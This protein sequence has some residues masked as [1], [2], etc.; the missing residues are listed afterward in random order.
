MT[1]L[2]NKSPSVGVVWHSG[3]S[4]WYYNNKKHIR[5]VQKQL[6]EKN[7]YAF[8]CEVCNKQYATKQVLKRHTKTKTHKAKVN[9]V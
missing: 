8:K 9:A 2:N 5:E 7:K 1:R 4:N 6:Y 3:R